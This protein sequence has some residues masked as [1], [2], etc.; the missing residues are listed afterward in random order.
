MGCGP[1]DGVGIKVAVA[2]NFSEAARE[3]AHQFERQ[4]GVPVALALGSTGKLYAQIEQGAPYGVFLAAD[5]ER[6]KLLESKGIALAGSRYTYALGQLVLWSPEGVAGSAEEVL[7]RRKYIRLAMA[8]P[9]L[10]PYGRA[11]RDVLKNLGLWSEVQSQ[12]VKGENISQTFQF[13]HSGNAQLAFVAHSQ[14]V[15]TG[16]AL[17]GTALLLSPSLYDP[18]EQQVV[19]LNHGDRERA[20]WTFLQSEKAKSIIRQHGYRIGA[21]TDRIAGARKE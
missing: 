11:A 12:I 5:R 18:I 2:S 17:E 8:N 7:R 15:S 4:E 3:L 14:I 13:A 10:A 21:D 20:F 1:S 19:L 16:E 6:P 9:D